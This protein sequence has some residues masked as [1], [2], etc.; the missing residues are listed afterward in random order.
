MGAVEKGLITIPIPGMTPPAA[1]NIAAIKPINAA[2][3]NLK[4]KPLRVL[5]TVMTGMLSSFKS[6][7]QIIKN[8]PFCIED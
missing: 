4:G 7:F 1:C 6:L 8:H 5:T 3:T 2:A